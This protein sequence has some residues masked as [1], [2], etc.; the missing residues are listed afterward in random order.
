MLSRCRYPTDEE[1]EL[2]RCYLRV[3]WNV[4]AT[5]SESDEPTSRTMLR[6]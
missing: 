1:T 6:L 2:L 3:S 4:D 5:S